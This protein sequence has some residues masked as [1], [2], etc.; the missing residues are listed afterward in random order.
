VNFFAV[1]VNGLDADGTRGCMIGFEGF[2]QGGAVEAH[3]S[4]KLP[5]AGSIPAP[6]TRLAVDHVTP[7]AL[8][9]CPPGAAD[10]GSAALYFMRQVCCVCQ[11]EYGV[12]PCLPAMHNGISH[13]YCEPC[14]DVALAQLL[15]EASR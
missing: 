8:K 15:V 5:V 1:V 7:S 6:A 3:E 11:R 13:G 14:A 4:H 10:D 2:L 12:K 9:A